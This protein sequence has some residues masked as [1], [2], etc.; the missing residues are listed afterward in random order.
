MDRGAWQVT[1]HGVTKSWTW[2]KWL[3]TQYI[4]HYKSH[5]KRSSEKREGKVWQQ[6]ILVEGRTS[7]L[8]QWLR[9]HASISGGPEFDPCLGDKIPP[10]MGCSQKKKKERKTIGDFREGNHLWT[11][12]FIIISFVL[13]ITLALQILN[14]SYPQ[15]MGSVLL[16]FFALC[17]GH[18]SAAYLFD[19][20]SVVA[21]WWP[22]FTSIYFGLMAHH[23]ILCFLTQ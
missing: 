3:S 2:L 23:P 7:L 14:L 5:N 13:I 22:Q 8:V 1:A 4:A 10:A 12:S 16:L 19:D 18:L 21:S 6:E 15:E 9:F 11:M 17:L 20:F